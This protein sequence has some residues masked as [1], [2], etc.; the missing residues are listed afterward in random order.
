M[1]QP[2][3][4]SSGDLRIFL[5]AATKVRHVTSLL[6]LL[7]VC[8]LGA[9]SA[10]AGCWHPHD[11]DLWS[12]DDLD[13]RV[14]LSFRNA[15][16]CVPVADAEVSVGEHDFTT[17]RAGLIHLPPGIRPENGELALLVSAEGYQPTRFDLQ[18]IAGVPR[19][20]RLPLSPRLAA[21]QAR[22][23][24]SWG[25]AEHDFDLFVVGDGR[26]WST[27]DQGAGGGR[28]ALADEGHGPDTLTLPALQADG[29]Y[30]VWVHRAA[31][32]PDAGP[33]AQ[34]HLY[35]S[36][37]ASRGV[38]LPVASAPWVEVAE[39]ERGNVRLILRP[40]GRGP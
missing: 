16:N 27:R 7:L 40:S 5:Q 37:G 15:I 21:G 9:T 20:N 14:T 18:F 39:I 25:S 33:A 3:G 11:R 28:G 10:M 6:G 8:W 2:R 24:L 30:S 4:F 32:P 34:V 31:G 22:F 19:L 13:G 38:L 36:D 26:M 1:R 12:D 17:D 35:F 23:V 29:R